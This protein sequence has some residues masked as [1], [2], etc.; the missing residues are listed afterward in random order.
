MGVTN[1]AHSVLT[2]ISE[3]TVLDPSFCLYKCF[4]RI[5]YRLCSTI[6]PS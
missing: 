4:E 5:V 1:Y 3:Q 2:A 6:F